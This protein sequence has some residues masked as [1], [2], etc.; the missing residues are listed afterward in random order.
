[1]VRAMIL[2]LFSCSDFFLPSNSLSSSFLA[3]LSVF[4]I[5]RCSFFLFFLGG[6]Q[7]HRA[8]REFTIAVRHMKPPSISEDEISNAAGMCDTHNGVN[9]MR[10]ACVI[11]MEKAEISFDPLLEALRY[12]TSHIMKRTFPIVLSLLK[13]SISSF[14]SLDINNRSFQDILRKIFDSFVD[15]TLDDCIRICRED[16][17]GMTRF[18]TWDIEDKSGSSSLYRLLP[19]PH[20]MAEIWH[21]AA[22]KKE[23]HGS[24]VEEEDTEEESSKQ[25]EGAANVEDEVL[26]IANRRNPFINGKSGN[27]LLSKSKTGGVKLNPLQR[28]TIKA[29]RG[30]NSQLSSKELV[31]KANSRNKDDY[32]VAA[33]EED[34]VVSYLLCFLF[35]RLSVSLPQYFLFVVFLL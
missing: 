22:K 11:A 17:Y 12:R 16:L 20:R 19:T 7:Y 14:S 21:L 27:N 25:I 34:A 30:G 23:K 8:I 33:I 35:S 5:L 4:S 13:K 1:M 18:V 32:K 3:F 9:F 26:A 2:C 15:K 29:K 6:A 24:Q 28:N 31:S 10:A